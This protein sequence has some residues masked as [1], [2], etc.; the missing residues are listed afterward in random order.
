MSLKRNMGERLNQIDRE[1][2]LKGKE[3][4]RKG[5]TRTQTLKGDQDLEGGKVKGDWKNATTSLK[6]ELGRKGGGLRKKN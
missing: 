3:N 4:R 2:T 5:N 1:K 6:T